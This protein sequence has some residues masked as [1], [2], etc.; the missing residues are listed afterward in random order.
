MVP[1]SLAA[2]PAQLATA[3]L[4]LARVGRDDIDEL[5]AAMIANRAWLE[6]YISVPRD[7]D[8]LAVAISQLVTDPTCVRYALRTPDGV[9]IGSAGLDARRDR[10]AIALSYWLLPQYTKQGFATE[11][12]MAL[13]QL[14]FAAT[15]CEALEIDHDAT[16]ESSA[17]VARTLGFWLTNTSSTRWRWIAARAVLLP[18]H[19]VK[20]SLLAIGTTYQ[21]GDRGLLRVPLPDGGEAEVLV[22]N[23]GDHAYATMT[24]PIGPA[25]MFDPHTLLACNASLEVGAL[26]I[27][28][29]EVLFRFS[30][31]ASG[32]TSVSAELALRRAAQLRLLVPRS[33][34][35]LDAFSA[36]L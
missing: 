30:C 22:S 8:E 33:Q 11:A 35:V 7:R 20:D 16:N 25:A 3:R 14:A 21:C 29:R 27:E 13:C 2:L 10:A 23:L 24:V 26:A 9:L 1:L 18:W 34:I 15:P 17:A 12:A 4:V 31:S 36:A 32:F 28:D 19:A 6:R 5:A